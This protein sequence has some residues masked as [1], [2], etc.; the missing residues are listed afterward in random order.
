MMK[1]FA[2]FV[3]ILSCAP[4]SRSAGGDRCVFLI[5]TD[6]LRPQEVFTGAELA[7]IG[8]DEA[9]KRE[10]W[11]DTP[12]ARREALMPFFWGT[13]ARQGQVYGDRA[14]GSIAQVT[15]GRNFSY[16]GYNEFLCGFPD[17]RIDS[18]NKVPNANVSVLEW[19]GRRPG[20]EGRIAAFGT[21]D[22]LPFILN[23]DRSGLPQQAANEPIKDAPLTER[24]QAIND[25]LRDT[26]ETFPGSPFDSFSYH[27]A[28]E[29]LKR[30]KPR[31]LY[32]LFGET[33]EWAHAGNYAQYLHA[34]RRVDRFL[35]QLWEL[36]QSMPEYRGRT[37]LVVVTDH[38]RGEGPQW[39]SHNA[40]TAGAQDLWMAAMGPAV[41]PLGSRENVVARQSQ[42]A[43]TVAALVGEDYNAA[44]PK[45]TP[46]L[47][48]DGSTPKRTEAP[49]PKVVVEREWGADALKSLPLTVDK[50]EPRPTSTFSISAKVVIDAREEWGGI[51]CQIQDNGPAES[52]WILGFDK[53]R[54][55]FGLASKGAADDD[56]CLTYLRGGKYATSK[57]YHVAATYDGETMILYVDG[58]EAARS[59]SQ[60]GDLFWGQHAKFVI[61]AYADADETHPMKGRVDGVRFSTKVWSAADVKTMS[62][63]R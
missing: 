35:K 8:K 45:A 42:I 55:Y 34:A 12:E 59:M 56:G 43:A 54:F 39:T 26:P 52:G 58:G 23:R 7:L 50:D 21:W 61:G 44:Q 47:P 28:V 62:E 22:V 40:S 3:L 6:G 37:S 19:L 25:L 49:A 41:K 13:I 15:N 24:Q 27:A 2:P 51:V 1:W 63:A 30:H 9:L 31:V 38:G 33:D 10:F 20:F 60:W 11:R 36:A 14:K 46:P 18:N 16:P 5:S 17:S 53:E 29:H 48:F 4:T 57:S 32:V